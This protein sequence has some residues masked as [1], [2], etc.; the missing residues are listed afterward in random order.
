MDNVY[1]CFWLFFVMRY[2]NELKELNLPKGQYA[3]FGSG[4][5]AIRG[6]RESRDVDLIVKLDLWNDLS[7]KYEKEGKGIKIGNIEVYHSWPP[8]LTE[9][10]I[11]K[12]I[13]TAD[14]IQKLPFVKLGFV[15]K[16]K[17]YVHREKDKKD[18]KLI[19]DF[20]AQQDSI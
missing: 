11:N 10:E 4:P 19:E 16:W 14:E 12:I 8:F 1:K 7:N 5:L 15:L 3:I 17:E 9:D 18:I 2:L 20:L 6:L 13:D